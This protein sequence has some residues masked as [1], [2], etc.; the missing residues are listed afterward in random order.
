MG[1]NHQD[2]FPI[3][4]RPLK[5]RMLDLHVKEETNR[6]DHAPARVR[7]ADCR[8]PAT[9]AETVFPLDG[10]GWQ[11]E[12]A[13]VAQ[14]VTVA[15]GGRM[16]AVLFAGPARRPR[17]RG[18]RS[19]LPRDL[20]RMLACNAGLAA[21]AKFTLA[22]DPPTA[23]LAAELLL[24][25]DEADLTERIGRLCTASAGR[26]RSS[27]PGAGRMVRPSR[28]P[29]GGQLSGELGPD[30]VSLCKET[31]WP[32]AQRAADC[33]VFEL[34]LVVRSF[35][36]WPSRMAGHPGTGSAACGLASTWPTRPSW[37]PV[38]GTPWPCCSCTPPIACGWH[39]RPYRIK[40]ALRPTVGRWSWTA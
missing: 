7:N 38:G 34:D 28:E 1:R 9:Y 39:G 15:A 16:A 21:A 18:A 24:G 19:A 22:D 35:R 20:Q 23:C 29:A 25:K 40:T 14:P 2:R 17:V 36:P 13:D 3:D 10:H 26:L 12:L 37:T 30:L 32:L 8:L 11:F 6:H 27:P 33:V 5:R 4:R 31:G